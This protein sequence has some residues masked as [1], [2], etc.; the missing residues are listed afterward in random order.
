MPRTYVFR[1][2]RAGD[3]P[4]VENSDGL[5]RE[6]LAAAGLIRNDEERSHFRE[7]VR[8]G[9]AAGCITSEHGDKL[10]LAAGLTVGGGFIWFFEEG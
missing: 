2:L 3:Y 4:P 5:F 8:C 10:Y 1:S 6:M 7:Q 9:L